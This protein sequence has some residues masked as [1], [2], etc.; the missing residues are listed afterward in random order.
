MTAAIISAG[1]VAVT[2][3]PEPV[4]AGDIVKVRILVAP[5]C[6]EFKDRRAGATSGVLG[7]EAAGLVV[8]AGSSTRVRAG[9]RVVVMPQYGCGICWLCTAGD[10]IHCPDQ[11]DVL[12]ETGSPYGTATYAQYVL[13]PDWLLLPVPADISLRHAALTCCGLGPGFNAIHTMGVTALDTVLVSGCGPVGLGTAIN[14]VTRG[15]RV[16]A[17]ETN[18]YRA[19]LARTLGAEVVLDPTDADPLDQI[20]ELTGGRGVDCAV[21]TSGAP[22]AAGLLA[23]AVRRR[24]QLAVVAWG[25]G[26]TLPPLVPLGLT[27]HGC[28]HWNHQRY[29]TRMWATVRA[30]GT[31]LDTLVTH[32]FPLEKVAEAMDVQDSGACGKV[33][34]LPFGPEALS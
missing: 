9:D 32:E 27:V 26:L 2:D 23:A 13:K 29:A 10:H 25:T 3:R 30:A 33:F 14:A 17:L 4:A 6:T 1:E 18:P 11:R 8:D 16:I 5:M 28:W 19:E 31:R 12:A 15:A 7:H 24:G 22:D 20:R 21:E 34:L